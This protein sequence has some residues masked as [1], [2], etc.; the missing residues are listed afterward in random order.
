[1]DATE[2]SCRLAV[3]VIGESFRA[4]SQ[5][6]R[7]IGA[8]VSVPE[9]VAACESHVRLMDA[10]VDLQSYVFL[11]T[12]D[13]LHSAQLR[14]IY[15]ERLCGCALLPAHANVTP[16][17]PFDHLRRALTLL[18]AGWPDTF[19]AVFV[20]RVDLLFKEP[21]DMVATHLRLACSVDARK[22]LYPSICFLPQHTTHKGLPR[23]NNMFAVVPRYRF[24]VL[25]GGE[26]DV[27]AHESWAALPPG[28]ADVMLDTY[29]DSDSQKDRNPVYR[30]VNR[31][32]H[33]VWHSRGYRLDR[34]TLQPV[35]VADPDPDPDPVA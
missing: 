12:Y 30:V 9:Q 34:M 19:D 26:V 14:R 11:H 7:H 2:G 10:L 16:R 22:I 25:L 31:P 27:V 20:L 29:H 1:M 6:S 13:T 5:F 35:H 24:D 17:G 28:A 18:P 33:A 23:V 8:D 3:L 32:E 15:G 4:G 21:L